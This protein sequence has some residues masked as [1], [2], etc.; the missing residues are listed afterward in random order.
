MP[1]LPTVRIIQRLQPYT[2]RRR[3]GARR[4]SLGP[5]ERTLDEEQLVRVEE[6]KAI[7]APPHEM[8]IR[9]RQMIV[10]YARHADR[11]DQLVAVQ[12]V[13]LDPA[14]HQHEGAAEQVIYDH[15]LARGAERA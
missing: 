2:R 7:L 12:V 1:P 14:S 6:R 10:R 13:N 5:E 8:W 4:V 15:G 11:P 3:A 9:K